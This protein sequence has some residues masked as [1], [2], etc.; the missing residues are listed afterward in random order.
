MAYDIFYKTQI[1]LNCSRNPDAGPSFNKPT[2]ALAA[3]GLFA[4]VLAFLG[5]A[6]LE[7][8]KRRYQE[9]MRPGHHPTVEVP[10]TPMR[11]MMR[12]GDGGYQT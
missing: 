2:A 4:V 10:V 7:S 6:G 11:E 12:F 9:I 5:R 8:E 1:P 3:A